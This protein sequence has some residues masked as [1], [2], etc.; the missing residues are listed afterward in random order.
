VLAQVRETLAALYGSAATVE[1]RDTAEAHIE[2][3]I[4]IAHAET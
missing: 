1:C 2:T 4:T 3:R